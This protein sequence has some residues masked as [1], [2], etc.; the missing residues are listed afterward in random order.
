MK[1]YNR[2]LKRFCI[3]FKESVGGAAGDLGTL[4]VEGA[5]KKKDKNYVPKKAKH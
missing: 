5:S 3:K 2:Y 1:I 4:P